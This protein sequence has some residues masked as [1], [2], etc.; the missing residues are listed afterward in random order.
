MA[1]SNITPLF[2]I[3]TVVADYSVN[4]LY[5]TFKQFNWIIWKPS[6][7]RVLEEKLVCNQRFK[8]QII[9]VEISRLLPGRERLS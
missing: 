4:F 5:K 1:F 3:L 8:V 2:I 6:A 9:L 7:T